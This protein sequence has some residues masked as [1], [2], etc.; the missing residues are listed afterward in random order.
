MKEKEIESGCCHEE[1]VEALQWLGNGKTLQK[2]EEECRCLEETKK[3][4]WE[5][6]FCQSFKWRPEKDRKK[7]RTKG[8]MWIKKVTEALFL[9]FIQEWE[10]G[11]RIFECLL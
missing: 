4:N 6:M 10:K 9:W 8:S 11:K 3:L 7:E 1:K 2:V 5:V